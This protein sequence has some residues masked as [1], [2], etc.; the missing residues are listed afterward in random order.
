MKNGRRR[1]KTQQVLVLGTQSSLWDKWCGQKV[2]RGGDF[3][4]RFDR[5]KVQISELKTVSSHFWDG[6]GCPGLDAE[7]GRW[8]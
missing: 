6:L 3:C 4:I 2:E 5:P 1:T 8:L 7:H